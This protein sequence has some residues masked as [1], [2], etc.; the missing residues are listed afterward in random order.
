MTLPCDKKGFISWQEGN[1]KL[2][3]E[4][5]KLKMVGKKSTADTGSDLSTP[6]AL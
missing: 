1:E 4:G 5:K 2:N 3:R 6:D